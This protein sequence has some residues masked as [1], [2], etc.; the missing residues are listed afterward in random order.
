MDYDIFISYAQ[1]APEPTVAL[2]DELTRRGF[3]PWYDVN[4]LPGQ[5]FGKVIDD[6]I[7][8]AKAV[9]TIWSPPALTSIWVPAESA[10]ALRQKK[11]LCV[12]TEDVVPSSLPTPFHQQH[13]PLWKDFASLVQALLAMGVRPG[14]IDAAATD[15]ESL[16]HEAQRDWRMV[17]KDDAEAIEAFLELYGQFAMFRVM[18]RKRLDA[19]LATGAP[20]LRPTP[21]PRPKPEPPPIRPEDV[22]LRLD[23]GMHTATIGRIGVSADGR[24]LATASDDKTVKLWALPEGKILRT[25][26]PPIGPGDEGKVNA[27]ALHPAG[28]WVAMGGWMSKTGL[29]EFVTVFD[30]NTGAVRA[31]LGPLP[32]VVNDL[33]VSTDGTRLAAGLGGK[34][35]IR[36]WDTTTALAGDAR[37]VFEDRAFGGGVFG[38][39]FGPTGSSAEGRL[40]ATSYDGYVRLYAPDGNLL[41]KAKAPGGAQPYGI[42]FSPDGR[43]LALGYTDI[44]RVDLRVDLIDAATLRSTGT[45]DVSGLS[46]GNVS[47]VAFLNPAQ[48]G[49]APRLVAGGRHGATDSP[50][51]I[52]ADIGYGGRSVWPG[53]KDTVMDIAALPNGGVAFCSGD[54]AFGLLDAAGGR[55]LFRG[56]ATADLRGKRR[57]HFTV[58]ADGRRLRFGL[59]PRGETPVLFD[60]AARQL[61]DSPQSLPE[62]TPANIDRLRIEGWENTTAPTLDGRP[63]PLEPY[64]RARSLA[65]A[66]D[67]GSF[68]L[69]TEWLLRRFDSK[70]TQLW[71]LPAPDVVWGVNLAC[72]GRLIF[73]AY[74]DGTIRW[75]RAEDGQELLA[76]FIHLPEGPDGPR[77]WILFTPEG[78]FQASSPQA[79]SLIGWHLNRGPDEAADF[80]PVDL[81]AS[82]YRKPDKIT[83]ALAE[84]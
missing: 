2:A 79:E 45:A 14:S 16:M 4:L 60:L 77:E 1:R 51:L 38:L 12:R 64:E 61:T 72:S 6:A 33:A 47:S 41:A 75:H 50:L 59:K 71:E 5:Y 63:L 73:A 20:S 52:W 78:Y 3:R 32:N 65:I 67:A 70:G 53:P 21:P 82:T 36:V 43:T 22:L 17:P 84:F 11:L 66:P 9:V 23:P 19:L 37:P 62:L 44:L 57:E 34:N 7:D 80:Y 35:G 30:L 83:A 10:R 40:A 74:A 25:L 39:A 81:F 55:M 68:V 29:N 58:S 48:P 15:L 28:R 31:R 26:R 49:D 24:L 69:G 56:P 76:L 54:P 13:V 42:A 27:I 18:A 8:R 46:G